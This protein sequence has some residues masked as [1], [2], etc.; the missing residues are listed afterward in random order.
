MVE[1]K[2]GSRGPSDRKLTIDE[3]NWHKEWLGQVCVIESDQD[4]IDLIAGLNR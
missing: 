1:I 2:D 4:A 3:M